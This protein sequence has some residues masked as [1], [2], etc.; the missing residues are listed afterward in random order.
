VLDSLQNKHCTLPVLCL[1]EQ[2]QRCRL[3][4]EPLAALRREAELRAFSRGIQKLGEQLFYLDPFK[5]EQLREVQRLLQIKGTAARA[6][7][8]PVVPCAREGEDSL[9]EVLVLLV[10]LSEEDLYIPKPLF[11]CVVTLQSNIEKLVVFD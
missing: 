10:M 4:A 8:Q 2:R 11:I 1:N 7:R 9:R 5:A 3:P 6:Q